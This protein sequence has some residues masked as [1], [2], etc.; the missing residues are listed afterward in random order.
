MEKKWISLCLIHCQNLPC[1]S[2]LLSACLRFSRLVSP[3]PS[4]CFLVAFSGV[5]A[6]GGFF[7]QTTLLP[8][9]WRRNTANPSFNMEPYFLSGWCFRIPSCCPEGSHAASFCSNGSDTQAGRRTGTNEQLRKTIK[10]LISIFVKQV[11]GAAAFG[12]GQNRTG[13]KVAE[14]LILMRMTRAGLIIGD[15]SVPP[16]P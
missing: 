6:L 16:S 4:M 8:Q 3:H 5:T 14:K 11:H 2:W 15:P 13:G 12:T 10:P 9:I 1:H 7:L